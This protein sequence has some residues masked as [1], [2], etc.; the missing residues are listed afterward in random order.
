MLYQEKSGNPGLVEEWRAAGILVSKWR[1]MNSTF[2]KWNGDGCE[3]SLCAALLAGLR[4]IYMDSDFQCRMRQPHP[5]IGIILFFVRC[6]MPQP[7]PTLKIPVCVNR[8]L[9]VIASASITEDPGF[10][11]CQGVRFFIS[12]YV[13]CKA[14]VKAYIICIGI[15]CVLVKNYLWSEPLCIHRWRKFLYLF[16]SLILS[17]I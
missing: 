9:V 6:R 17:L 5:K 2:L 16:R 4:P 11:S 13:H 14:V 7:H 1:K 8:P 10:E 3:M 15:L 12:L